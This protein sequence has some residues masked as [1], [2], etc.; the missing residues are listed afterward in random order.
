MCNM[1]LR[2]ALVLSFEHA[3]LLRS[4]NLALTNG[5]KAKLRAAASF[6]FSSYGFFLRRTPP[7]VPRRRRRRPH[8]AD[9]HV[10]RVSMILANQQ[11]EEISGFPDCQHGLQTNAKSPGTSA[12]L[13]RQG[14]P[15][16]ALCDSVDRTWNR[17]SLMA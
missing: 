15:V 6:A 3:Y 13:A 17:N 16:V 8:A 7:A 12:H 11:D 2:R 5:Q 1:P 10:I 4:S 9:E 14:R